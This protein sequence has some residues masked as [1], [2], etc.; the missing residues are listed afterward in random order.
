[1]KKR[2]LRRMTAFTLAEGAQTVT[3]A[4][5]PWAGGDPYNTESSG[6]EINVEADM[7]EQV[8]SWNA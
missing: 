2:E 8:V 3:F 1:M 7:P 5:G 4:H 6:H